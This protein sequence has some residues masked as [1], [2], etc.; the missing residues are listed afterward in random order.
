MTAARAVPLVCALALAAGADAAEPASR[1]AVHPAGA[2][3][4]RLETPPAFVSASAAGDLSD[5][6][7]VDPAGREVP[8][9]VVPAPVDA[10]RFVPAA[11]LRPI[12]RTKRESGDEVDLGALREIAGV[13][14][15]YGGGCLLFQKR[16]RVEGSADGRRWTTLAADETLYALDPSDGAAPCEPS[17]LL[18]RD[19]IR[20]PPARVR[21]VRVV[22]DDG[23]T[24]RLAPL[25]TASVLVADGAA[26]PPSPRVRLRVEPRPAEPGTSRYALALP[27]PHLPVRAIVVSTSTRRVSR[28]ARVLEARL[29]DGQLVPVELGTGVLVRAER[30]GV[31]AA[32]L[33]IATTAP[34][35]LELELA[36]EDGDNAPL[37]DVAVE[38]ELAPLTGIVFESADGSPLEAR[39]GDP[40]L[41]APRYDLEALRPELSRLRPAVA[42]ADGPREDAA[43]A[44]PTVSAPPDAAAAGAP[45]ERSRFRIAR[46]VAA[47]P[48]G[49]ATLALDASVLARSPSLA[50][51]RLLDPEGRQ[52]P[53][54]VERRDA[55]LVVPLGGPAALAS[56]DAAA[57]TGTTT[58]ALAVAERALPA[59]RL[60]LETSARV[61]RREVRVLVDAPAGRHGRAVL[62]ASATWSHADPARAAP[63][64]ALELPAFTGDRLLLA[65]D[66]G[67]NAPLP[68]SRARLL[69]PAVRLRFFHPGPALTLVHGAAGLAPARYDL[70]LLAPRLRA[71][72]AR[73][74]ALGLAPRPD[75]TDTPGAGGRA[76]F[77]T[78]LAVAV[79]GLLVLVG[80]LVRRDG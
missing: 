69:V 75:A 64:L 3:L 70:A 11:T 23:R 67:D 26:R 24:P 58:L 66:D 46:A 2:G 61:F 53:Y 39:L 16:A 49:L 35:E 33:G 52:V 63:P 80:R 14:V 5:L 65:V 68:V 54:L 12:P 4:Q 30:D 22:L 78:V 57:A 50:D 18:A 28:R 36:V 44:T 27:G 60:L 51:V 47:S 56:T 37:A 38:A 59:G 15:P 55:P 13:R 42:R 17:R 21:L 32:E 79:G 29:A 73:E 41:R 19:T 7:L 77:W 9:L 72:P 62:L 1:F 20:F 10:P 45:V 48:P 76:A 31:V 6:R 25:H 74:V 40:G 43:A 8:Y 34:E 71:A